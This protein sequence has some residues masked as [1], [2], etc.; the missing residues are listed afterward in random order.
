MARK[1]GV[2]QISLEAG[3]AKFVADMD[4]AKAKIRDFGASGVSET[5]AMRAGFKV[6]EG[7]MLNNVRAAEQFAEK[8]LGLGPIVQAAFPIIGAV[9][10]LGIIGEAGKKVYE[11][12]EGIQSAPEKVAGAFRE[13]GTSLQLSNDQLAIT[14]ARLENDIAKLEGRRPNN[15]KVALLEAKEAADKLAE[16]LDKDLDALNKLLKEQ[17]HG[18]LGQLFGQP[19]AGKEAAEFFGGET[20]FGGFEAQIDQ[21]NRVAAAKITAA[22]KAKD[23]VAEENA[24]R[25]RDIAL[26]Q[27]WGEA[28]E[29][30]NRK[31]KESTEAGYSA[32][33]RGMGLTN[34]TDKANLETWQSI[35]NR[36][37]LPEMERIRGS[38]ENR[39]L[40]GQK[41]GAEDQSRYLEAAKQLQN[42]LA[43]AQARYTAA[44][45]K[46]T[47]GL[48][49]V[50]LEE[51]AE[52]ARLKEKNELNAHNL[53]LIHEIYN[54]RY[55]TAYVEELRKINQEIQSQAQR[56]QQLEMEARKADA[57]M[58]SEDI[59]K[60]TEDLKL[61]DEALTKA[62]EEYNKLTNEADKARLQHGIRMIGIAGAS[63]NPVTVLEQQQDLERQDIQQRYLDGL[64]N[65]TNA[66]E[67]ANVER[68]KAVDLDRLDYE[69]E[70]KQ[71]EMRQK[72]MRDFFREMTWQAESAG[73]ILYDSMHRALDSLSSE[74]GKLLTGQKTSFGKTIQGIGEGMVSSTVKSLATRGLGEVGKHIPGP[75]GEVL[76][77]ASAAAAGKADGSAHS[78]FH[79]IVDNKLEGSA[80]GGGGSGP[81]TPASSTARD[82]GTI[83]GGAIFGGRTGFASGLESLGGRLMD[84]GV[85]GAFDQLSDLFGG[86]LADGGSVSPDQAYIVGER[87]PEPFFPGVPGMIMSN[88]SARRVFGGNGSGQQYTYQVDA[89][90]ADL[91][92]GNRV[93][94]AI[95]AAHNSSVATGIRANV[96]RSKRIPMR[97]AA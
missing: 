15:L 87:G 65:A 28:A 18:W 84:K 76:K 52:I 95:E 6:I 73:K 44:V 94:R 56:W 41:A 59:K 81:A 47:G 57:S 45:E 3:T 61:L 1:A 40:T 66:I 14:N 78:P 86:F 67:R 38:A 89:R 92:A 49:A 11:F 93:A 7:G 72:S 77:G 5:K 24:A 32:I 97:K 27:K 36:V 2:I 21:I 55:L 42:E 88:A 17:S 85:S 64:K 34:T 60:G 70:E 80:S 48:Q 53:E 79:V 46:T 75:L 22:V 71:A 37:I 35:L 90:G 4:R 29:L 31:I 96:E 39:T 62:A 19:G 9:A 74:M 30:A 51:Q 68:Q 16:A 25:E 20:G 63:E 54:Y 58:F 26:L 8:M 43:E 23:K 83:A 82:V 91:G 69:M 10:F 33:H 50:N 12:I 13:F